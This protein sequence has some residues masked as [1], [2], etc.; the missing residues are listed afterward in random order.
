MLMNWLEPSIEKRT[1]DIIDTYV[2]SDNETQKKFM[3]ILNA[4]NGRFIIGPE[5]IELENLFHLNSVLS[6]GHSYRTG[7][8]DA[9]SLFKN[10]RILE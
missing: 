6:I 9:L 10:D 3:A 1:N 2:L 7:F 4:L 8:G 5:L